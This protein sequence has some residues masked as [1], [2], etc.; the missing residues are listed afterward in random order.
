MSIPRFLQTTFF[1]WYEL[2]I[3]IIHS[4]CQTGE[5][6]TALMLPSMYEESK[7]LLFDVICRTASGVVVVNIG[8]VHRFGGM[9]HC[10]LKVHR[11]SL[12][13]NRRRLGLLCQGRGVEGPVRGLF[14]MWTP[15]DLKLVSGDTLHIHPVDGDG[16]TCSLLPLVLLKFTMSSFVLLTL[17]AGRL[18]TVNHATW[19]C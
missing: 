6:R 18:F 11:L 16:G 19:W 5:Q 2:S 1:T 10:I 7:P 13:Q 14:D 8:K 12:R 15:R 17:R 3:V 9:Q 4:L